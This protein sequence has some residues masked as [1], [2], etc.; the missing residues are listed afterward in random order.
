MSKYLETNSHELLNSD[1][2]HHSSSSTPRSVLELGAGAGLPGL[3]SVLEGA[4]LVLITFFIP[5]PQKKKK[6]QYNYHSS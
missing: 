4:G 1:P 6:N 2:T 5:P 3:T